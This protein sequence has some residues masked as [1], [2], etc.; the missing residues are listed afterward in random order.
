[1]PVKKFKV[2]AYP[3]VYDEIKEIEDYIKIDSPLN[4]IKVR[5]TILKT[6]KSLKTFP[7]RFHQDYFRLIQD[8]NYRFVNLWHY[9]IHYKVEEKIVLVFHISSTYKKPS[10]IA[11]KI[12]E[13]E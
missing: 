8:E 10:N 11:E 12:K 4:S 9:N 1:M 5:N 13:F 7:F 2:I 6:I 3:S